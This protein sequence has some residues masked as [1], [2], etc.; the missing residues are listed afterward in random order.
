[1]AVRHAAIVTARICFSGSRRASC[2]QLDPALLSSVSGSAAARRHRPQLRAN[3]WHRLA[4]L[5]AQSSSVTSLQQGLFKTGGRLIR[6]PDTSSSSWSKARLV[7]S[8]LTSTL[9]RQILGR[10]E[11]LA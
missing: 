2:H 8:H 4:L 10:I 11:R 9:L 7:E 3:L 6:H 1:M 5:L